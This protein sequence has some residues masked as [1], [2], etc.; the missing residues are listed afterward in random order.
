MID[1]LLFMSLFFKFVFLRL[2]SI[3]RY[4]ISRNQR[5]SRA[6][7]TRYG[8]SITIM[9]YEGHGRGFYNVKHVL[10]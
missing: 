4:L 10:T 9:N 5:P 7:S 8:P 3:S 2:N 1:M 6:S